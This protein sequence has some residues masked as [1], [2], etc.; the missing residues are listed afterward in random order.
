MK[1]EFRVREENNEIIAVAMVDL[2]EMPQPTA[3]IK[4]SIQPIDCYQVAF[5]C[6]VG[7][8]AFGVMLTWMMWR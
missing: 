4:Q 1:H 5:C 6:C 2:C 8:C 3:P 7:F